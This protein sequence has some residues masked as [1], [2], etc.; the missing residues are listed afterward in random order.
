MYA[1]TLT[2]FTAA[3]S[4]SAVRV[5][6]EV[7]SEADLTGFELGRKAATETSYTLLSTTAVTGQRRYLYT[8]TNVYRLRRYR[9]H[10]QRHGRRRA[11]HLPPHGAQPRRRPELPH[12]AGRHAQRRA[13][14]LGHHQVDVPL[15]QRAG[16]W[17]LV[18]DAAG[19]RLPY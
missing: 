4:G 13:A 10:R 17:L 12:R 8:D 19:C 16:C 15:G 11:L 1:A 18:S 14:L 3:Y 5:E 6:W 9:H 7:N 2:L